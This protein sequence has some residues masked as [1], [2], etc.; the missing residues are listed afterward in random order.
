VKRGLLLTFFAALAITIPAAAESAIDPKADSLMKSMT[1]ALDTASTLAF[2]AETTIDEVTASGQKLQRGALVSAL[3]R[4]PSH[5]LAIRDGDTGVR[6]FAYDGRT[7]KVLDPL[8]GLYATAEV[9]GTIDDALAYLREKYDMVLPL[10]DLISSGF[11]D[12]VRPRVTS[13]RYLGRHRVGRV[14]CH[15]LA[16]T[17]ETVDWQVWIEDGPKPL[18]RK[19]VITYKTAPGSPQFSAVIGE[20]ILSEPL[21]DKLLELAIP[22]DASRIEILGKEGSEQ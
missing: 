7:L 11:Y 16:Y 17:M 6:K 4:R 15:H 20:W 3:V 5:V 2:T 1:K 14:P 12:E 9:A 22:S 8:L 10:G 21:P 19:I 13:G 18:P